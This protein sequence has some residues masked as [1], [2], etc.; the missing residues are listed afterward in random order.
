MPADLNASQAFAPV[1]AWNVHATDINEAGTVL[2]GY[3]DTSSNF[4]T[5]C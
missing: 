2:T 5:S 4:Y 1:T 3:N